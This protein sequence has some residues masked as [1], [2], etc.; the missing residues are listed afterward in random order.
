MLF[1]DLRYSIRV[2]RKSPTF[3][4]VAVLS[5]GLGIGAS[6][7]LF[8]VLDAIRLRTLP[9]RAPDELAEVRIADMT[10]ARGSVSRSNSVT[11]RIWEEIRK[12]Q[13]AFAGVFAWADDSLNLSPAGEVR[14]TQGLWVSGEFFRVL[15]V[16]PALGRLIVPADDQRGCGAPGAVI[17]Y[18][19]WQ[20]E[21]GGD[22]KVVGRKLTLNSHPVPILGVTPA[23][24]F[25]LE[26]GQTFQVALPLC[27]V[28]ALQGY[29]ALESG[30]YWWL[31]VMGRMNSG[32]PLSRASA[33]LSAISPR[34]LA[35]SLPPEYPTASVKNYLAMTL[36]AR[37]AGAGISGLRNRYS[38]PL[39]MLLGIACLVLLITCANLANLMLARAG[40]RDREFALCLAIGASR[41][42]LIRQ[43]LTESL[44]VAGC[45]AALGLLLARGLSRTLV[46]LL[47]ADAGSISLDLSP[48]W[49]ILA[50]TSTL[51]FLTCLLFGLAPAFRVTRNEPNL[52]LKSASRG[53]TAG[54]EHFGLR[55]LLTVSQVALS[56]VLLVGAL[57]FV[58]S[59]WNLRDV[60]AGFRQDG[61]LI[62]D[63]RYARSGT[64]GFS[65]PL[66]QKSLLDRLRSL[67]GV[68][69]VA[70]TT[71]VPI[72]G[73]S[74]GN[75]VWMDG[76]NAAAPADAL[77]TRIS[78][79]YFTTLGIPLL[80]GRD[81][82]NNDTSSSPKVAIVNQAFA[83][84]ITGAVEPLGHRFRVEATPSAPE[85]VYEIVGLVGN[86]KYRSLRESVEP[87][88]YLP[89]SQDPRPQLA[90]QLLIRSAVPFEA[91]LPSVRQALQEV[92]PSARFAFE[93]LQ[94]QIA[95][96]LLPER[97]MATLS[98]AFGVLA[99]LLSA[100]GLYGVISYLVSRRRNEIGIR[101]AL[102]AARRKILTMV[103]AEVC[104]TLAIGLAAGILLSLATATFARAMLFGLTPYDGASLFMASG[105][106]VLV[107]LVSTFAPAYRA[108]SI[109]PMI[110]LRDE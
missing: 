89:L 16:E 87:V 43:L 17:S 45:G 5:L 55:Q 85:T 39:Q 110:A 26:V 97:L 46:S 6:T 2:L 103:L 30:T 80:L 106:L 32:W 93:E 64:P 40:A 42:R 35:S 12:S 36:V 73:S 79:G 67:P 65:V 38:S 11:Y 27:S 84:K 109:D 25:G 10:G 105:L 69:S 9:V 13:Q 49:R 48:D 96:S 94:V 60:D 71:V 78:T 101:M 72:S 66:W 50:F 56:L 22:P 7:A 86:T 102:G 41:A 37:P 19:F 23:G 51:G 99:A 15:G 95:S 100:T 70:D 82:S 21:F 58:R 81:F 92:D 24:F 34:V 98:T 76:A 59:L 68:V 57:L 4:L 108:A 33:H 61:I 75:K 62:A 47:S 52:A 104:R 3:A 14:M 20:S 63:L 54:V 90:D 53:A 77:F 83:R 91:L 31:T 107:A 74:W 28:P 1:R 29:N 18:S 8:Q 44:V 88:F